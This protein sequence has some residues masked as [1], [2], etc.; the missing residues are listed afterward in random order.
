MEANH[1]QASSP[2]DSDSCVAASAVSVPLELAF[3]KLVGAVVATEDGTP[4]GQCYDPLG[5]QQGLAC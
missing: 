3:C 1:H 2:A 4:Y 5:L